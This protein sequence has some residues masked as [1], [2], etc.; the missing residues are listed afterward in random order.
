VQK[1][2]G[3]APK[4]ATPNFGEFL[5]LRRWV[6]KGKRRVGALLERMS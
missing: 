4:F 1:V 6:N 3:I 2:G 5:F